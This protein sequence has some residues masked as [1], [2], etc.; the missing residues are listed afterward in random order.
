MICFIERI[1]QQR[2]GILHQSAGTMNLL[3]AMKV[4]QGDVVEAGKAGD[5]DRSRAA[6]AQ[7]PLAF[8]GLS[9]GHECMGD[10]DRSLRPRLL[11]K[12]RRHRPHRAV[13]IEE[14]VRFRHC[15]TIDGSA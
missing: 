7:R 15:C 5:I 8:A 6:D 4:A 2:A 14:A 9:A 1:L 13:M 10:Q 3:G 11:A 12:P